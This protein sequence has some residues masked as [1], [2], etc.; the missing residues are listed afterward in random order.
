MD[1]N[2]AGGPFGMESNQGVPLRLRDHQAV[3]G[4]GGGD[5]GVDEAAEQRGFDELGQQRERHQTEDADENRFVGDL[6]MSAFPVGAS[7]S[8]A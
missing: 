4:Q 7:F 1:G 8:L 5:P 6:R 2:V 3:D